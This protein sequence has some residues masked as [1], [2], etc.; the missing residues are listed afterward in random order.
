MNTLDNLNFQRTENFVM[1][2]KKHQEHKR[3]ALIKAKENIQKLEEEIDISE[4][5]QEKSVLELALMTDGPQSVR[6]TISELSNPRLTEDK[7]IALDNYLR[8]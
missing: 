4:R 1:S 6:I 5:N 7:R 3:S 2:N 8:K